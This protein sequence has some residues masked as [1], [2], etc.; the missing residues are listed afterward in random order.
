LRQRPFDDARVRQAFAHAI[1]RAALLQAEPGS[2]IPP[3]GILPPGMP[4]F[5]PEMK[6]LKRDLV[7]AR[8]LLAEAGFPDGRGLPPIAYTTASQS[9]QA[10]KLFE[11]IRDQVAEVGFDVRSQQLTWREFSQRLTDQQLQCFIVTWV[12]DIPDPDSFLYPM[13]HSKGSANFTAYSR[14]QVDELLV[15]GRATRSSLERLHVYHEAERFILNDA[16]LV[17]LYHPLSAIAVQQNVRGLNVTPMGVGNLALE[18]VWLAAP[19]DPNGPLTQNLL[20]G[21]ATRHAASQAGTAG[22]KRRLERVT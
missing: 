15:A 16:P 7:R 10:R 13:C 5:T 6:L 3:N 4:G 14:P 21:P 9:Q 2:R 11:S 19:G 22:R 17:P 1:D 12:A 8:K 20:P 18:K